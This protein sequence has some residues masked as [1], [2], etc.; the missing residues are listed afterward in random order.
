[1]RKIR[2]YVREA[3]DLPYIPK[4]DAD[5]NIIYTASG[6]KGVVEKIVAYLQGYKNR[7]F[8]RLVTNLLNLERLSKEMDQL[9]EGAKEDTK[10]LIADLFKAEDVV[11]TRVVETNNFILQITKDPTPAR[12][13]A[14]S[15]VLEELETQLTPELLLVMR[16][17]VAKHTSIA[18]ARLPSIKVVDKRPKKLNEFVDTGAELEL[19]LAEIYAKTVNWAYAYD[20]RLEYLRNQL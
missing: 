19:A 11:C 2:S 14:Y 12:T 7:K 9:K 3:D 18:N 20:A 10:V 4:A 1:M 17:L 8:N 16:T 6:K 15:K 13:V 5:S